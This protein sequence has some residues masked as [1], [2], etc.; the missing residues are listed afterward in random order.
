MK[1]AIGFK[2][3]SGP[4]GGGNKFVLSLSNHLK[5]KGHLV[6]NN[7]NDNDIDIILMIDP[8]SNHPNVTFTLNK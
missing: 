2:T 8:R 1:V 4:W 5:K 3:T 7:L 6:T